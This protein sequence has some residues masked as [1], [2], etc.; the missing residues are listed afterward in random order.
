MSTDAV[1]AA[2]T[3]L[4]LSRMRLHKALQAHTDQAPTTWLWGKTAPEW[5]ERLKESPEVQ[6]LWE[7]AK[8]LLKNRSVILVVGAVVA[9]CALVWSRPRRWLLQPAVLAALLPYLL[10]HLGAHTPVPPPPPP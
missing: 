10:S 8:P 5:M 4:A 2:T 1:A 9:G 3:R 7:K 6:I